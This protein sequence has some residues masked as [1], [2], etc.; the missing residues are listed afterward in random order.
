MEI[1][2]GFSLFEKKISCLLNVAPSHL[3]SN[4]RAFI[5]AF[6]MM[7]VLICTWTCVCIIQHI[8]TSWETFDVEDPQGVISFNH[9]SRV[10]EVFVN[11]ASMKVIVGVV[12]PLVGTVTPH[13][14]TLLSLVVST[15]ATPYH[16]LF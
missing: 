16:S 1:F 8:F 15:T 6:H 13:I 14:R 9:S 4:C 12:S 3:H 5:H 2:L 7:L 10:F 11:N